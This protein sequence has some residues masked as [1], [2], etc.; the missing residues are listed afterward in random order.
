LGCRRQ[1]RFQL[2][3]ADNGEVGGFHQAP[4]ARSELRGVACCGPYFTLSLHW[5]LEDD[6]NG[7][8]VRRLRT[9][10]RIALAV[11]SALRCRPPQPE[12]TTL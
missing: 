11:G 1:L 3:V 4:R 8:V 5:F 10:C 2:G 9:G 12:L 6:R 7:L